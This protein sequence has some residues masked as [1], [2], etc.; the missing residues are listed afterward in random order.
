M[1]RAVLRDIKH[2]A[3]ES[4]DKP[5]CPSDG[6]VVKMKTCAVCATDVKIYNYGHRLLKLPRVLG[7]ELAGE[8]ESVGEEIDG[9]F[10]VG[11]RVAVC[12]GI[13]CGVCDCCLRAAPSMCD[14]LEAFGYHYDGG[15]Q[16]YMAVPGKAVRCGGVNILSDTLSFEEASIAELLAC[17][18][19]GQR[20][21]DFQ[22]GESVLVIGAGPVGILHAQ[23][24]RSRGAGAV[25]LADIVP[26]K[27]DLAREICAGGLTGTLESNDAEVFLGEVRR[28]TGG[29]GFDQVMLCCGAPAAQQLGLHC[30]AKMGCVNFFGGLPK[31][32]S[33]VVLDTNQIHYKQCRVVGTHGSSPLENRM[34]LRMIEQGLVDAKSLVTDVITLDGLEDALQ[35]GG[36]NAERL[37]SVVRFD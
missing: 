27:L 22:M 17:S 20:L 5:S 12:A 25:W 23:L 35:P 9:S 13:N 2:M 28:V 32:N 19:N 33:N 14:D 26:E 4:V 1:K 8:I 31:G 29:V 3:I 21:S 30:V 15:Y 16:E 37:K 36:G 7:H 34:A 24:A 6:L 10:K 11:Q 18:I